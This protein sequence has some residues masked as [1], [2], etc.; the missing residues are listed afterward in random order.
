[1]Y[2][3]RTVVRSLVERNHTLLKLL[4][5]CFCQNSNSQLVE[6]RHEGRVRLPEHLLQDYDLL[7]TFFPSGGF[8]AKRFCLHWRKLEE[9]SHKAE[10][11]QTQR[12]F[13][14]GMS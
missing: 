12:N 2:L 7:H 3:L 4:L 14:V 13:V 5:S 9:G 6:E 11:D 10:R 1:M 8:K